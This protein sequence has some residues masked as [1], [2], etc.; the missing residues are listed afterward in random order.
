MLVSPIKWL[1]LAPEVAKGLVD[2]VFDAYLAGLKESGWAGNEEQVR[3]TYM[4][5]LGGESLRTM[6]GTLAMVDEENFRV[7]AEKNIG[8]PI[9]EIFD[10]WA[11]PMHFFLECADEAIH[12]AKRLRAKSVYS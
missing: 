7:M 10:R 8:L 12:L 9:E 6:I 3:L 4:L 5:V 1:D 2:P 11:N